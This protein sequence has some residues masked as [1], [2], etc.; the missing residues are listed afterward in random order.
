[1]LNVANAV[2]IADFKDLEISYDN[3]LNFASLTAGMTPQQYEIY[4]YFLDWNKIISF[5]QTGRNAS[6]DLSLV[7]SKFRVDF[8]G[9]LDAIQK[10]STKSS[11][12]AKDLFIFDPAFTDRGASEPYVYDVFTPRDIIGNWYSFLFTCFDTYIHN[13]MI[14]TSDGGSPDDL[15]VDGY[16]Q[17]GNI[18]FIGNPIKILPLKA[19]FSALIDNVDFS[20]KILKITQDSTDYYIFVTEAETTDN[21]SE[22][23][24]KGN[25]IYF[26]T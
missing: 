24:I 1:L 19:T 18:P 13:H 15:Y 4:T 14:S 10:I 7:L 26:P 11:G 2:T 12:A 8:S 5:S 22:Q 3:E 21:L 20:E 17:L 25:L 9:I 23:K 16:N 6:E